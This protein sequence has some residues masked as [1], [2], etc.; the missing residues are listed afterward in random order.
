[1]DVLYL[2]QSNTANRSFCVHTA[3]RRPARV[4]AIAAKLYP[5]VLPPYL[6][7]GHVSLAVV[8]DIPLLAPSVVGAVRVGE[9]HGG[10]EPLLFLVSE[11]RVRQVC[12]LRGSVK[13]ALRWFVSS[14]RSHD[15]VEWC[16]VVHNNRYNEVDV[17]FD[18]CWLVCCPA[19]VFIKCR[20]L[21]S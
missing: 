16:G 4:A 12:P 10:C 21:T 6:R 14:S 9:V 17:A 19:K 3:N 1:M 8:H 15:D 20:V 7:S 11:G 5:P 18:D 2:P 13:V